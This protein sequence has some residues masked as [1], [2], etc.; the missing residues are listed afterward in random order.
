[1]S[2]LTAIENYIKAANLRALFKKLKAPNIK[3]LIKELSTSQRRGPKGGS[4]I[5][6]LLW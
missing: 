6:K 5:I 1:M 4:D 2:N 3:R